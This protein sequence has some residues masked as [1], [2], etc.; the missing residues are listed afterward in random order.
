MAV[1]N[2]TTK[3]TGIRPID[4]VDY[5]KTILLG[6][7]GDLLNYMPVDIAMSLS[8][9]RKCAAAMST[10]PNPVIRK[11]YADAQESLA[12]LDEDKRAAFADVVR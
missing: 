8:F 4:P 2:T 9:D 7:R 10:H 11:T 1:Q 12:A 6:K 5:Y 3:R